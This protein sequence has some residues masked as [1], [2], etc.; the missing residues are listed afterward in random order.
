MDFQRLERELKKRCVYSYKWGRKQC[1]SW[2][3]STRFIYNT[4]SV[5]S[6]LQQ[7]EQFDEAHRNYA[8][9]RWYNFWSAKGVEELFSSHPKVT[10][11]KNRYDKL[12][13]FTIDSIS[14]D[15]KSTR[16]PQKY[17]KTIK[18]ARK[19]PRDLITWLYKNQSSEGRFHLKNRLFIVVYDSQKGTHWKVKS[20]IGLLKS[21][22]DAYVEAFS[23][24]KLHRFDFG[25]GT[26]FSD[27]IW[28]IV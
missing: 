16:F 25:E 19:N 22:I 15:H 10:A 26:V 21:H 1:D 3:R 14:F 11:Q 6:L 7:C 4:Y 5:S 18:E 2:D 28:V 27:I 12:V 17:S 8:L 23:E 24:E 9:N 20:E 13:D